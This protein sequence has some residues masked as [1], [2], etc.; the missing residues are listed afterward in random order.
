LS[1]RKAAPPGKRFSARHPDFIYSQCTKNSC[2]T[3]QFF[4]GKNFLMGDKW[5]TLFRTAIPAAQIA[6]VCYGQ[7]EICDRPLVVIYQ[8]GF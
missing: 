2:E 4:K 7:T 3:L 8:A 1:K 5:H 6:A